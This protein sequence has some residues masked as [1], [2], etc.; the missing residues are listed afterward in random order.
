MFFSFDLS[1]SV[2]LYLS[3]VKWFKETKKLNFLVSYVLLFG[4]MSKKML[5]YNNQYI[6][7][8]LQSFVIGPDGKHIA[9]LVAKCKKAMRESFRI[10]VVLRIAVK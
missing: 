7:F 1:F 8:L 9:A 6:F 10:D 4:I 5:Y 2:S 3:P